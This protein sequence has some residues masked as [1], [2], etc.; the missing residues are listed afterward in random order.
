MVLSFFS[1]VVTVRLVHFTLHGLKWKII[2]GNDG[3]ASSTL[4]QRMAQQ[5][6]S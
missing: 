6:R 1:F 5:K 3:S 4:E 2:A